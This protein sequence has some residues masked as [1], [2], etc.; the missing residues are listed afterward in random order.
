M[1]ELIGAPFI[2]RPNTQ[3]AIGPVIAAVRV[4][5]IHTRGLRMM[6]GICSIDVPMPWLTRPPQR[7]SLNDMTAKPTICAQQPATAAPPAR[8][9]SPSTEQIAAEEIG[10]VSATP[11]STDT[12]MPIQNGWSF[13]AWSMTRPNA[14]A[15]EPIGGA[16]SFA[17]ATPTNIVTAGV[18]RISTLVSFET[19]LPHS[20]AMIAMTSTASGPPAP[21]SAFAA[22]PTAASENSTIGSA[23]SA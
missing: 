19:A 2:S 10:S 9:V 13:V 11:T 15:A 22:Q 3:V 8:P 7:F 4:G 18:T 16:I 20:A 14:P 21:P 5:A 12:A 23:L 17:S 6:F 1:P